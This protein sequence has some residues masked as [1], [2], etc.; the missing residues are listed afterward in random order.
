MSLTALLAVGPLAAGATQTVAHGL[1]ATPDFII[2]D[3]ASPIIVQSRNATSVVFKNNGS[4][5]ASANFMAWKVHSVQSGQ[6]QG[7]LWQGADGLGVATDLQSAAARWD[8]LMI[9]DSAFRVGGTAPDFTNWL[10]GLYAYAF[11]AGDQVFFES[12]MPHC[13]AF[14]LVGGAV[15]SPH[16]HLVFPNANAGDYVFGLEYSVAAVN[17]TFI[18]PLTIESAVTA[19]PAAANKHVLLELPDMDLSAYAG[20][21]TMLSCRLY[22]KSGVASAYASSIVLLEFDFH[23]QKN[24]LG[25][26]EEYVK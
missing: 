7:Y 12:Q 25:S 5:S 4:A 18:A 17:G 13:W 23:L 26:H 6:D 9:P 8:D 11:K 10:G 14:N 22:R 21:S 16:C 20:L 19:A 2:P 15:I 3:R 24:D 1:E